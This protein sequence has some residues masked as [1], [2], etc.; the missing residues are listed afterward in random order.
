MTRNI[1]T[2]SWVA[3]RVAA[4]GALPI[5]Y[6]WYNDTSGPSVA[7]PG[8]TN[9]TYWIK[10]ISTNASFNVLVSNPFTSNTPPDAT[11]TAQTRPVIVPITKYAQLVV[12][13]SPVAYWRLDETNAGLW[14]RHGCS[15]FF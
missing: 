8:A 5:K 14:H 15:R 11:L 10:G 9:A 13:D 1:G 3:F 2:N 6:Q 7:I 12:S 4:N